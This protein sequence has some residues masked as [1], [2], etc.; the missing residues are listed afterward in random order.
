MKSC[1]FDDFPYIY[2]TV[3][4]IKDKKKKDKFDPWRSCEEPKKRESLLDTIFPTRST[5]GRK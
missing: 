3:N 5:E 2:H 4:Y 1:D